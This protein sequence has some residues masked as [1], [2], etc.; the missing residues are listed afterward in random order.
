MSSKL[1]N[2]AVKTGE[3]SVNS[4]ALGLIEDELWVCASHEQGKDGQVVFVTLSGG[5]SAK[6]A[7]RRLRLVIAY[8]EKNGV[9]AEPIND[10]VKVSLSKERLFD[11]AR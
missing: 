6:A 2:R 8:L 7:I 9:P 10:M 5:I 3:A 1:Q 11:R 4:V